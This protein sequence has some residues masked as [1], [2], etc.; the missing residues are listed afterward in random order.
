MKIGFSHQQQRR[1]WRA[2]VTA[3]SENVPEPTA[4]TSFTRI[5]LCH[6]V[7][8]GA[9]QLE[10]IQMK[11]H[12]HTPSLQLPKNRWGEVVINVAHVRDI[13]TKFT[14]NLS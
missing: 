12:G 11:E 7:V 8:G 5:P 1:T 13:G 4:T 2:G 3:F 14:D 9:E 6:H 10:I